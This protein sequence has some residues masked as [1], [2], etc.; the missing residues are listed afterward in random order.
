[1][2]GKAHENVSLK[3]IC[4]VGNEHSKVYTMVETNSC[5]KADCFDAT[6]IIREKILLKLENSTLPSEVSCLHFISAVGWKRFH[7]SHPNDKL[8]KKSQ[9]KSGT[10][11]TAKSLSY[12][13]AIRG[14]TP[15]IAVKARR[16]G[17]STHQV[18]C[19]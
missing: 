5:T 15:D 6:Q 18:I 3:A 9:L 1:M 2:V 19:C 10:W 4:V 14:V 12:R 13:Q 11:R 8:K 7:L 17:G 16:V